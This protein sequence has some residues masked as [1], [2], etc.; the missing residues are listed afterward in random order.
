M[1]QRARRKGANAVVDFEYKSAVEDE[2]VYIGATGLAVV[3]R[4]L[5]TERERTRRKQLEEERLVRPA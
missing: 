3:V 2:T 1:L 5:K 4:R